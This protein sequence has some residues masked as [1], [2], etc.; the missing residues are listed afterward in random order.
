MTTLVEKLTAPE[1]RPQVVAA[2]V[3]LVESEVASK[4]GLSGA[5]IKTGFK[6][7]KAVKP[8][9][10]PGAVDTLLPEFAAA[11]QPIYAK[12]TEGAGDPAAAFTD[13][14]VKNDD[15]TAEALLGVT[16]ARAQRAANAT[17]KKTYQKLR[18]GAKDHVKAAIP[19]LAR[20]MKPYL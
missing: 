16:D 8:G 1:T 15:E 11:M 2:C 6:V 3:D 7:V 18:G 17:I 9:M 19:G 5:A 14:I 12:A 13:Y 20:V 10:V 4:K